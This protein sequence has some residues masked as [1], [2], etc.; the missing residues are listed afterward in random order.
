MKKCWKCKQTKKDDCFHLDRTKTDG[1]RGICKDCS[2]EAN[3][4]YWV[5]RT[6]IMVL[7]TQVQRI[8]EFIKSL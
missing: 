5:E 1:L 4:D 6:T 3:K 2:K 8:R 7:R